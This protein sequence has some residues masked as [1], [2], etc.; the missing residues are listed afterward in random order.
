MANSSDTNSDRPD[1]VSQF[2]MSNNCNQKEVDQLR[3]EFH[4]VRNE[5]S[6][7]RIAC[8][9]K[10]NDIQRMMVKIYF[11]VDYVDTNLY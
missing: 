10:D 3:S 4:Q 6:Q 1:G 9:A 8:Q 5:N 11:V 2:H 7:L